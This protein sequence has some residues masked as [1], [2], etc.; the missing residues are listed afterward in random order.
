VGKL[1]GHSF[2]DDL[3]EV[4]YEHT[5]REWNWAVDHEDYGPGFRADNGFMPRV[6]MRK[7][8]AKLNRTFWPEENRGYDRWSIA[9]YANHIEDHEGRLPDEA[10]R[11]YRLLQ[12]RLRLILVE[13]IW[14]T[15]GGERRSA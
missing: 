4:R 10:H 6:D 7:A 14:F 3:W 2:D 13:P 1:P 5:T 8:Q 12:G 11:P 15:C 9:S